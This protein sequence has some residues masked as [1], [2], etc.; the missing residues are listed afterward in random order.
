MIQKVFL[1]HDVLEQGRV[2]W[3]ASRRD[4]SRSAAA[5]PRPAMRRRRA[6]RGAGSRQKEGH[7]AAP[8]E[9]SRSR[10]AHGKSEGSGLGDLRQVSC[11]R[12]TRRSPRAHP[13]PG[14]VWRRWRAPEHDRRAV[15]GLQHVAATFARED[16][17]GDGD[18]ETVL[19]HLLAD[20]GTVGEAQA[21]RP[22]RERHLLAAGRPAGAEGANHRAVAFGD[23]D[24]VLDAPHDGRQEIGFADEPRD[25]AVFRPVVEILG[26]PT[27]PPCRRS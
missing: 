12:P 26:V 4:R 22:R 9:R 27:W 19:R 10:P 14:G 24:I 21:L 25:E 3:P 20:P 2:S 8:V 23:H 6:C 16:R 5:S 13:R 15:A 1:E 11:P 7:G 18:A 17:L